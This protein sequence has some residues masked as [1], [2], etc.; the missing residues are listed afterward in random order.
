MFDRTFFKFLIAFIL[1]I[2]VSST[3]IYFADQY[4][5]SPIAAPQTQTASH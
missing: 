1:I 2:G 5:S 4:K 3:V